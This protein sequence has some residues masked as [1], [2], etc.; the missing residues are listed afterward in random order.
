MALSKIELPIIKTSFAEHSKMKDS[1][2]LAIKN[3]PGVSTH[4]HE[5]SITKSD[6]NISPDIPRPYLTIFKSVLMENLKTFYSS[7]GTATFQIHNFWYQQYTENSTHSWHVH[8]ASHYTNIYYLELPTG[9]PKTQIK[10]PVNLSEVIDLDVAE[11]DLIC[12]PSSVYHRSPPV[13]GNLRKTVI[14]FNTSFLN[15]IQ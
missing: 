6:W 1:L 10:N 3:S 8:P 7:F 11:G 4:G 14:S 12:F 15:I 5:D 9:S 13:I 2:L